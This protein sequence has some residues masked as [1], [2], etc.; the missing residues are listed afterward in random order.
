M[1]HAKFLIVCW[2]V[3]LPWALGGEF[4]LMWNPGP[5]LRY[6]DAFA[7]FV[8]FVTLLAFVRAIE[9][10]WLFAKYPNLKDDA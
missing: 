6:G 5:R 10:T 8:M 1:K 7:L 3:A 2:L 4:R 9:A